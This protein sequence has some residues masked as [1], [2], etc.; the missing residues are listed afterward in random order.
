MADKIQIQYSTSGV[1]LYAIVRDTAGL[2]WNGTSFG[3][4]ATA[5][6]STYALTMAEQG[7]ASRYYTVSFPSAITVGTYS[8]SVFQRLGGS[9]AETDSVLTGGSI[10]W[11]GTAIVGSADAS[12]STLG[13]TQVADTVW[14]ALTADHAT[15][16]TFGLAV[17]SGATAASVW[18][19]PTRTI[20]G[21]VTLDF[22]QAYPG[23]PVAGTT[24][25]A[26]NYIGTRLDA[27]IT[28]R[29]T[30]DATNAAQITAQASLDTLNVSI[31]PTRGGYID[32]L[33]GGIPSTTDIGTAVWNTAIN[34]VV[35]ANYAGTV[36]NA[37]ATTTAL[38]L[39]QTDTTTLLSRLTATRAGYLDNLSAGIPTGA[40]I[41]T[42]VWN[43]DI[44]AISTAGFAGKYLNSGATAAS[45]WANGTRTLTAG[46]NI[47][48]A[49]GVG[50]TGFNDIAATDIVSAGAITTSAGKVSRV[51]L[52]D[53][54]TLTSDITTKTGYSLAASQTFDMTGNIT[55][56]LSGS[57]GSVTAGVTLTSGE[58]NSV[59]TALLDLTDGVET[60]ITVREALRAI[61]AMVAGQVSGAGTGVETFK[62][63]GNAATTRVVVDVT[64]LGNRTA[65]ALTL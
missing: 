17:A 10:S 8:V 41:T 62:A 52:V 60:D 18:A 11:N 55:G 35:T 36:L 44:S 37:K 59:A 39:V 51:A 23:S 50:V 43:K 30:G 3:T 14:D 28:S 48:L 31:S 47:V 26:F 38:G 12:L 58:R 6:L 24:G 32:A 65:V 46:T 56:N 45:I 25:L 4:Y 22:T 33:S 54:T 1:V 29:G 16:G 5:S 64:S 20:T 61:G 27:T 63:L 40:D 49:K 21:A 13:Q 53:L 34:G 42:L 9:P 15:A 7:T 57:V 19:Y 2:V